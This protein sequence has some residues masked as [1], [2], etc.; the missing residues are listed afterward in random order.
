MPNRTL[1]I[2]AGIGLLVI[3]AMVGGGLFAVDGGQT[4]VAR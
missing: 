4:E 3:G 1:L 2:C